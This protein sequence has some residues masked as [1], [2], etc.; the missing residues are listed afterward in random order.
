MFCRVLYLQAAYSAIEEIAK[1]ANNP[2]QAAAQRALDKYFGSNRREEQVDGL[3]SFG[4][5]I[6][7]M[8]CDWLSQRRLRGK[9]P[10]D[11]TAEEDRI[12]SHLAASRPSDVW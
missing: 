1:D 6:M 7:T 8:C 11:F 4:G 3:V 10:S 5:S 9:V 12:R 2:L